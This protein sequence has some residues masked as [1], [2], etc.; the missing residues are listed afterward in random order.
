MS[1]RDTAAVP[2]G[3][4]TRIPPAGGTNIPLPPVP[5][6]I[7]EGGKYDQC[8]A[9]VADD[10]SGAL[11]FSDSWAA[12]GGGDGAAHCRALA[13]AALGDPA[14]AAAQLDALAKASSGAIAARAS[15]AGQAAQA[16]AMAGQ[17]ERAFDSAGLALD[18]YGDD[19][20]LLIDHATAA[21]RLGRDVVALADLDRAIALDPNR[22]DAW[23]LRAS[24]HR[25][26]GAFDEAA[27]DVDAALR[28]DPDD[29]DA[30]LE[31]GLLRQH[32]GDLDGARADWERTMSLSP[33]SPVSDLAEQNIALLEAGPAMR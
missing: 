4:T 22:A 18:L 32:A 8:L 6:R 17:G 20:D 27:R 9:M 1:T 15:I 33:D 28:L 24:A 19:P 16:W 11:A 29:A 5:P 2:P 30:L 7:A 12:A 10:P 3:A 14:A 13:T 23:S 21:V 31:R 25:D 26:A